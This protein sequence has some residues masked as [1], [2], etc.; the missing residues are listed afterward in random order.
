M[1]GGSEIPRHPH[2]PT[3][4][5]RLWSTRTRELGRQKSKRSRPMRQH[6]PTASSAL[7]P[8]LV[9][10]IATVAVVGQPLREPAVRPQIHIQFAHAVRL[11]RDTLSLE[12]CGLVGRST[13]AAGSTLVQLFKVYIKAH[14]HKF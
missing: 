4:I 6:L 14:V 12:R 2:Y 13:R 5:I 11:N 1:R 9:F 3:T 7:L 8:F 10:L